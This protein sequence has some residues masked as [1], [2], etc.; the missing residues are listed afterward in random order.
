MLTDEQVA[1]YHREGFIITRGLFS[2]A[3]I[4]PL[5]DAYRKDPTIGGSLYGMVDRAGNAHPINIWVDLADDMIGMIPRMPRMVDT[6]EKL[7]GESCYHWHS[8]F[9]NKP[10]GCRAKVDW[11]QDY[12]SWYDDGI[13]FPTMLTIGIAL[14]DSSEE[15]GCLQVI[16]G[17]HHMGLMR[18]EDRENFDARV[19]AAKQSPG[20]VS[21][22]LKQGDA[23]FFHS[24]TLHGSGTNK[25]DRSRLMLFTSYNAATNEPVDGIIGDNKKGRFMGITP[26]ERKFRPIEKVSDDVLKNGDYRSAFGHTPFKEPIDTPDESYLQAVPLNQKQEISDREIQ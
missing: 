15:N 11:H 4:Q 20:L 10:P 25:S 19:N 22:D 9:T 1:D 12:V 24:N 2:C 3:E 6:V 5:F 16:R 7:F 23:V 8:K 14:E 13:M 18:H 21:C 26:E 17:S